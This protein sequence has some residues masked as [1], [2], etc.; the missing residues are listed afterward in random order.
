MV[1]W[2]DGIICDRYSFESS[3]GW[4]HHVMMMVSDGMW[5]KAAF[6]SFINDWA[7]GGNVRE[8]ALGL[9]QKILDLRIGRH[10]GRI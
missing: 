10:G 4:R 8:L 3:S 9:V 1:E 2:M 5:Q 7:I 6:S